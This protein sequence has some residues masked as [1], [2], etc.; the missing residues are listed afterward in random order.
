MRYG[1]LWV[2]TALA[3]LTLASTALANDSTAELTTGGLVLSKSADIEMRSEDLAVSEKEIS[4]GY[5]F[6]NHAASDETVTVAFPM[7]D[8]T[9]DG[10]D[11]NIAFPAPDSTNFL[12]F[13]TTVD[14]REV[15]AQ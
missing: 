8:V 14:G 2:L 9:L 4:V 15:Q 1:L 11:W 3:C 5:R 13:H 6:F 7:P 12:E 10:P